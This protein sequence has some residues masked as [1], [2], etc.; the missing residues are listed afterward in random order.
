MTYF[1]LEALP[2][3]HGDCLILHYGSDD[4]PGLALIDGG[5]SGTWDR[6]LK[7]RLQALKQAR[8]DPFQIDLLMVSHI[9]DDHIVGIV[10]F[11]GEWVRAT[12]DG[13]EWPFPVAQ[14]W[15][16]SFERI[17]DS[18]PT[19]VTA[20]VLASTEGATE[21]RDVD[22]D[23]VDGDPKEARAAVEVLASVAKGAQLRK[24]AKKLDIPK[25]IGF[26]GLVRPGVGEM[27]YALDGGLTFHVA[28]P[29]TEQLDKLRQQFAK[30]LPPG[31]PSTLAAYVDESVP[32]LSS[33]VVLASCE[34]K[35]MLLTGDARGDYLLQGLE[36]EGLLE[37][38]GTLHVDLLKLQHHGSVRNTEDEF[39]RRVTAD[40][41]VVSADGR[42]G[43]P[44]RETFELLMEAR[45]RDARYTIHLTY[46]CASIDA[47]RKKGYDKERDRKLAKGKP[48]APPWDDAANAIA[49]LI[50][51]KKAAGYA[52]EVVEPASGRWPKIDLLDPISI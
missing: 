12:E 22:L 27:P 45:G 11:T 14:L 24:D 15:H 43:N 4:A 13:Q 2:A 48:A 50:Q 5:P 30:Q 49:A 46:P 10:N 6:S 3:Q 51:Q 25:N 40:H 23:E 42:F 28:G 20:S 7:P 39:Y 29:L 52:F 26:D 44:D 18:D 37:T 35:T 32:N 33:I 34:G 31:V 8:G 1:T 9:D 36:A 16:N 19:Q 41:Y 17:S 21:L 47:E 38:G